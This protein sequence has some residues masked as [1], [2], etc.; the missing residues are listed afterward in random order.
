VL[1]AAVDDV[2]NDVAMDDEA[3][4]IVVATADEGMVIGSVH[5]IV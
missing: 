3:M 5:G 2:V 4:I 1:A